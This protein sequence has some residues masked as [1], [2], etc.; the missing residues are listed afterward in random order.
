MRRHWH[1][2]RPAPASRTAYHAR[3]CR[4]Q[5]S[6]CNDARMHNL[7]LVHADC[8]PFHSP[9]ADECLPVYGCDRTRIVRIRVVDVSDVVHRVVVVDFRDFRSVVVT[10]AAA[11]DF[12]DVSRSGAIRRNIYVAGAQR[13]PSDALHAAEGH[14]N[15][16]SA[17]TNE[18]NESRRVYRCYCH[19]TGHPTPRTIND[20]PS[21]VVKRREAPRLGVNP[22]PSPRSDPTPMARVVGNPARRDVVRDPVV[23]IFGIR[24]P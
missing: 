3:S 2:W 5:R 17:P 21:A 12:L 7:L 16:K 23:A 19:R 9:A 22:S 15:S 24:V 10:T 18:P 20:R 6:C 14:G 1:T 11:I 13:V 4:S 8:A